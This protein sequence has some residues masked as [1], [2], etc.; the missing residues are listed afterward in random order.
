M[1]LG[2]LVV[3]CRNTGNG[4]LHVVASVPVAGTVPTT[5][6]FVRAIARLGGMIP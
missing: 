5:L 2:L 3:T 6:G 4:C 1:V